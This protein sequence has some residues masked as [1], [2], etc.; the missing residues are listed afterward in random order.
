MHDE[1]KLPSLERVEGMGDGELDA[2]WPR[3]ECI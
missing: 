2:P 3:M 1:R